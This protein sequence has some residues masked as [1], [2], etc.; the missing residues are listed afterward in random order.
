MQLANAL[1]L[2]IYTET[3]RLDCNLVKYFV[4]NLRSFLFCGDESFKQ[5]AFL[6]C[7]NE[8]TN[9]CNC[10]KHPSSIKFLYIIDR[11]E[12]IASQTKLIFY[13]LYLLR[14]LHNAE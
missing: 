12:P 10:V 4:Y 2:S 7:I 6:A 8:L 14:L 3:L 13:F 1:D 9:R 5:P 11:Q